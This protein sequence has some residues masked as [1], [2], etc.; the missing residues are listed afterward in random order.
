MEQESS[1][2]IFFMTRVSEKSGRSIVKEST[3][4]W[5]FFHLIMQT[6]SVSKDAQSFKK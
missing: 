3:D 4:F 6:F 1:E 2:V 5:L